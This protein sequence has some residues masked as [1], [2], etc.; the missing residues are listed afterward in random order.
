MRS[1]ATAA[2][3]PSMT[4]APEPAPAEPDD[5]ADEDEAGDFAVGYT[6]TIADLDVTGPA[7]EADELHVVLH[8]IALPVQKAYSVARLMRTKGLRVYVQTF[9]TVT[10]AERFIR[11][12]AR[13]DGS[14]LLTVTTRDGHDG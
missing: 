10:G 14:V 2:H 3:G 11:F 12:E 5:L 8:S 1:D 6:V 4:T 7:P 13:P 9:R